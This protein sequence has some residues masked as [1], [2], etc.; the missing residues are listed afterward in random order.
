MSSR[1]KDFIDF[2]GRAAKASET[3]R[4]NTAKMIWKLMDGVV[5]RIPECAQIRRSCPHN[6][7]VS[8]HC[9]RCGAVLASRAEKAVS[10]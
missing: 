8:N 10:S 9:A 7:V 6:L 4:M 5:T 1:G 3:N 2:C